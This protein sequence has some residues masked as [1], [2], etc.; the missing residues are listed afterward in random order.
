M[1][2]VE[3]IR[4]EKT[5]DETTAAVFGLAKTMGKIPVVVKDG[6]GFLVNRLLM[7]W[8]I[9]GMHLLNEGMDIATVDRYYTHKFGMP[10]GPFRLMDEVGLDVC[11]KV[12]KIFKNALGERIEVPPVAEKLEKSDRLGKK[13]GKGFYLYDEKGKET[14]VDSSVYSEMGVGSP[15]NPLSEKQCIERGVFAMINEAALALIED[16]IVETPGEVDLAMIM[17]TGFPPF[18]GGLL[19]YADSLGTEYIV[20]ELE[21]YASQFGARFK[22][23]TPLAN[24]ARNGKTFYRDG[25]ADSKSGASPSPATGAE[26]QL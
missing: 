15:S 17:G 10:M 4:G 1:P 16:Q 8:M 20:S 9:E 2:L 26:A 14:G 7:P 25:K 11:V 18:R 6:P 13:N 23:S 21:M 22:P 5:S 24:L 12:V 19:R 3:V